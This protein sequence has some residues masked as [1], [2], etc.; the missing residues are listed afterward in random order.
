MK[1]VEEKEEASVYQR[2]VLKNASPYHYLK[3]RLVLEDDSTRLS[4]VELKYFIITGLKSLY[5]E[6]GAALNFDVLK[7]DEDTLTAFLR[8]YSRS[9]V[10][11]WSSLTLL[12]SYQNQACAFRVLQVSPF[13]L[14]LT[15][16]SR[17]LQLD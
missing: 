10:K 2:V 6:V 12:G 16:N 5:G 7:Y 14:A 15:G 13:L 1:E 11:L 3:V 8:V 9:L 4:A 17:D